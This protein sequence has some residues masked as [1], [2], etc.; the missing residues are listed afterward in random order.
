M[1]IIRAPN[2]LIY[3]DYFKADMDPLQDKYFF[4]FLTL[5]R[6]KSL[7]TLMLSWSAVCDCMVYRKE[8]K[9][10]LWYIP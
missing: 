2:Y 3:F 9:G 6:T 10:E 4:L 7:S 8:Q 1:H 5:K